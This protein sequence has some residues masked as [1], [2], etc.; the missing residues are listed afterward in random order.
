MK[1]NATVF[2][3]MQE[4]EPDDMELVYRIFI[5]FGDHKPILDPTL[6]PGVSSL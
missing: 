5:D 2:I 1:T 3:C 6:P 4:P